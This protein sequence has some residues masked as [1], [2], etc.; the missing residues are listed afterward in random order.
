MA[1]NA[2][3]RGL[4][5]LPMTEF[6]C[7]LMKMT[8]AERRAASS[9]RAAQRYGIPVEWAQWWIDEMQGAEQWPVQKERLL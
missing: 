4:G 9:E 2:F 7:A 1:N 8:P 3:D 5:N 6:I